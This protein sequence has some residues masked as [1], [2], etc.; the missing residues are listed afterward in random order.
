MSFQKLARGEGIANDGPQS[1][2]GLSQETAFRILSAK[3]RRYVL[4]YLLQKDGQVTLKDL[5]TQIAAWENDTLRDA[6]TYKERMRVYTALKQSHLPKMVESNLVTFDEERSV[7]EPT[8]E[9]SELEVYLD[10]VP[11]NSISWSKYYT[12]LGILS[13]GAVF[14]AA[15]GL[16]PFS[17]VPGLWWAAVVAIL[18]TGSALVHLARD[19]RMRLGREGRPPG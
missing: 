7:I 18:F 10:V 19:R 4:H 16:V 3:R 1:R 5:S 2:A 11:H 17:I 6:V 13:L 9:A 8:A 15:V 14:A 12:G